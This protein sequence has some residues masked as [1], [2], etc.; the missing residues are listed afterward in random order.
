VRKAVTCGPRKS[1]KGI[2]KIK[3]TAMII[4]ENNETP[5]QEEIFSRMRDF[6]G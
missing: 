1:G 4:P 2:K 3:L 5:P 6:I